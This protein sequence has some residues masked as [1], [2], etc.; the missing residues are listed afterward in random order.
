MNTCRKIRIILALLISSVFLL[1]NC[2]TFPGNNKRSSSPERWVTFLLGKTSIERVIQSVTSFGAVTSALPRYEH[3][4]IWVYPSEDN[5]LLK[6]RGICSFIEVWNDIVP[7]Y[8]PETESFLSSFL[9]AIGFSPLSGGVYMDVFVVEDTLA[10]SY[11]RRFALFMLDTHIGIVRDDNSSHAWTF[12]EIRTN[13]IRNG[14][15]F[16]QNSKKKE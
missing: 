4:N 7:G 14:Y 10:E 15:R 1:Q 3:I 6:I 2:A 11:L 16:F 8:E 9:P 13:A 5:Q 12:K